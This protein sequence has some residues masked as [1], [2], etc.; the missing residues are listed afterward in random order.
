M[1]LA[2]RILGLV[3][4]CFSLQAYSVVFEQR[5]CLWKTH[6]SPIVGTRTRSECTKDKALAH[7][8]REMKRLESESF[9]ILLNRKVDL[10]TKVEDVVSTSRGSSSSEY[11]YIRFHYA[12]PQDYLPFTD[13]ERALLREKFQE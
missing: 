13:E 7:A 4:F 10:F 5:V 2:L 8:K 12:G 11:R 9:D 6:Q 1:F 3:I